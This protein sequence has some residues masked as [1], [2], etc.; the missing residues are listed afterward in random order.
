[1]VNTVVYP[2]AAVKPADG[3]GHCLRRIG[4]LSKLESRAGGNGA[5]ELSAFEVLETQAEGKGFRF[6]KKP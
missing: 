4:P 2:R 6:P 5:L 1:M 3:R